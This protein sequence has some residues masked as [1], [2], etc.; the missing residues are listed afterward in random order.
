MCS[1]GGLENQNVKSENVKVIFNAKKQ[2][3]E[4]AARVGVD[5]YLVASVIKS[6]TWLYWF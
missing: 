2:P 1:N 5:N 4:P 3:R 6:L